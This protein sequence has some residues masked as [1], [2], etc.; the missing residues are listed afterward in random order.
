MNVGKVALKN[1]MVTLEGD[2]PKENAS[3]FLAVL[4][5]VRVNFTRLILHLSRK[6]LEGKVIFTYTDNS[7]QEVVTEWPF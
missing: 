5:S 1:L 2:F 6:V 4:R 7:N 3:L